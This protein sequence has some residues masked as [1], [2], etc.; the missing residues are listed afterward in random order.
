MICKPTLFILSNIDLEIFE[1]VVV[2]VDS[3]LG[4]DAIFLESLDE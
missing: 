1:L 3:L 4:L 2:F